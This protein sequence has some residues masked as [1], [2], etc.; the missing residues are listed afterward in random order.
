VVVQCE[1]RDVPGI[2]AECE[3]SLAAPP[4]LPASM[5]WRLFLAPMRHAGAWCPIKHGSAGAHTGTEIVDTSDAGKGMR[6]VDR[7]GA[8]GGSGDSFCGMECGFRSIVN[9]RFTSM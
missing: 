4:S 2:V 9:A 3:S 1:Q 8:L 6:P 5:W 7:V